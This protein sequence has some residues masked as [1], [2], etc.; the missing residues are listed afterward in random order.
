MLCQA[1]EEAWRADG[2]VCD[3]GT[4]VRACPTGPSART[5]LGANLAPRTFAT[6]GTTSTLP[7]PVTDS[8]PACKAGRQAAEGVSS[9]CL[10][11]RRSSRRS[12][13][14]PGAHD[15][16]GDFPGGFDPR[17]L[18]QLRAL[19]HPQRANGDTSPFERSTRLGVLRCALATAHGHQSREQEEGERTAHGIL[20][21]AFVG[22]SRSVARLV[23]RENADCHGLK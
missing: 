6:S 12:G 20:C 10:E 19:R 11:R 22:R 21:A 9:T 5:E 7:V 23:V 13:S 18:P 16:G 15:P 2:S 1:G 4:C 3:S 14:W 17:P 8:L